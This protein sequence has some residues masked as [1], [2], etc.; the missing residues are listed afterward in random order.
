MDATIVLDQAYPD[1]QRQERADSQLTLEQTDGGKRLE[2]AT[3]DWHRSDIQ[4]KAL[5]DE[6]DGCFVRWGRYQRIDRALS[7]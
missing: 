6:S 2:V 1:H 4:Q 5:N 3:P 7:S